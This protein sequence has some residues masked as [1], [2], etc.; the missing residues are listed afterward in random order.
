MAILK[1][2]EYTDT[3]GYS[4]YA[5]ESCCAE[6]Q[7]AW[8]NHLIGFGGARHGFD[9]RE[10]VTGINIF[11][12]VCHPGDAGEFVDWVAHF[13]PFCGKPLSWM[14]V[15]RGPNKFGAKFETTAK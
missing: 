5:L 4:F 13:C 15:R 3:G 6:F 11:Q 10:H 7:G 9:Y 12:F 1:V 2:T 8:D 14:V